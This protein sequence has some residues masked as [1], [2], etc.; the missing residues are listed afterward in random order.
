[1]TCYT[2]SEHEADDTRK[3]NDKCCIYLR[4]S[5]YKAPYMPL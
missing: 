5:K 4:E 1:M 2:K 3:V